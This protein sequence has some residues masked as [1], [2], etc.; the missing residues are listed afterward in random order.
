MQK[1]K[2]KLNK[3]FTLIETLVALAIF[4]F[5]VVSI[6]VVTGQGINDVNYSKNKLSATMLADEGVELVRNIRDTYALGDQATQGWDNFKIIAEPS[7]CGIVCAID[8]TGDLTTLNSGAISACGATGCG[9]L[10]RDTSINSTGY[11]NYDSSGIATIFTRNIRVDGTDITG[12]DNVLLVTSTVNWKQGQTT[13]TLT[14]SEP[15]YNW[16]VKN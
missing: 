13:K 7:F 1:E 3:G 6:V 11:Y 2:L 8:P 16:Y 10:Y 9:P 5:S 14:V 4:A 15:I 12:L